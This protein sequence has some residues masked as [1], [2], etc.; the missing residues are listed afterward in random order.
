MAIAYTSLTSLSLAKYF[1]D[2]DSMKALSVGL[3]ENRNLKSLYLTYMDIK[4]GRALASSIATMS[5][6]TSVR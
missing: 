2:D 3:W 1:I 4:E 5:S 6:L